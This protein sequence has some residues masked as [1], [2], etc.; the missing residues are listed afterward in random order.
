MKTTAKK[1]D[2]KFIVHQIIRICN[3]RGVD[4]YRCYSGRGMFGRLC[5]GITGERDECL[6]IAELVKRKTGKNYAMDNLG[7]DV[8][9]YFP[10]VE[11]KRE[12]F[13]DEP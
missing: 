6:P 9:V 1:Y 5:I 3:N 12:W 8:I 4:Y 2:D 10:Y 11:D 7:L 13:P